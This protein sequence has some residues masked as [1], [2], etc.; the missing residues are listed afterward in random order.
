MKSRLAAVVVTSAAALACALPGAA[1][2]QYFGGL[3]LTPRDSV[4]ENETLIPLAGIYMPAYLFD[5]RRH[6]GLRLDVRS[7]PVFAAASRNWSDLFSGSGPRSQAVDLGLSGAL[8][9]SDRFS[10]LGRLGMVRMKPDATP[11]AGFLTPYGY[12]SN[13]MSL[14]VQYDLSRSLGLRFEVAR[15][16]YLQGTGFDGETDHNFSFGLSFKF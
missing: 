7:A 9:L 1:S 6:Y 3:V 15:Q 4:Y 13:R 12:K 8:P 11:M 16:R 2:A 14:G 5:G 10:L